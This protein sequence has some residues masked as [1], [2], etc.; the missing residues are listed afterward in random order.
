MWDDALHEMSTP[1]GA[2]SGNWQMDK[3]FDGSGKVSEELGYSVDPK[4][5]LA[6]RTIVMRNPYIRALADNVVD[7]SGH[8]N[9]NVN[10]DK[11]ENMHLYRGQWMPFADVET[12]QNLD[13][14]ER[15]ARGDF[16]KPTVSSVEGYIDNGNT[17]GLVVNVNIPMKTIN[18][19]YDTNMWYDNVSNT[20]RDMNIAISG[21]PSGSNIKDSVWKDGYITVPMVL[22]TSADELEA[23]MLNRAWQKD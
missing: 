3:L 18:K 11:I 8:K 15:V 10:A 12:S 4:R 22:S 21:T 19:V 6:P 14:E 9:P 13:I 1:L 7:S 20:L 5:L 23:T 17:R 16:G 2:Y